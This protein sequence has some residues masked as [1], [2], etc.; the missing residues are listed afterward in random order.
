LYQPMRLDRQKPEPDPL[1]ARVRRQPEAT[2]RC[3]AFPNATGPKPRSL[4]WAY[5]PAATRAAGRIPVAAPMA[6]SRS[7]MMSSTCS[8]PTEMRTSSGVTPLAT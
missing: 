8:M 1:R 4:Q 3:R 7:A 5:A 2:Q 6:W